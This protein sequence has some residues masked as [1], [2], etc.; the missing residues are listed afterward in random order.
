MTLRLLIIL[1]LCASIAAF[2]SSGKK[3][4]SKKIFISTGADTINSLNGFLGN[5]FTIIDQD[6]EVAVL[7]INADQVEDI[8]H[9]MHEEH[10]RCGGFFVHETRSEALEM[11]EVLGFNGK[12]GKTE[13]PDAPKYN[14]TIN[15]TE[16]V[17]G[18]LPHAKELP[19]RKVIQKLSSF[20][21]RHYQTETGIASSRWIASHWKKLGSARNDV[22]V[23]LVKHRRFPQESII[24]TITGSK[25]PNEIIVIGGHADSINGR[26]KRRAPG[27]DDN[28]S[29]IATISEIIRV[30]ML[31]G[32]KPERTVQF[33]GYA[34]EEV[35]LL[36]SADIAGQYKKTGK[37]V[38]G[39]MQLDM[40][41]HHGTSN[42]DIVMMSD[43][44][45][46][47]QNAFI[48]A[49]I[50]RYLGYSWGYSKCGY[51]CSDHASWTR[52][53]YAASIPFES[54]MNDINHKIHTPKDTLDNLGGDASH[55]L[56]FAKL[57]IA[58]MMELAK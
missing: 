48:G 27:A 47:Y 3:K 24:M 45:N 56:K 13:K 26:S 50:D 46:K 49:L 52:N 7:E 36:G 44:T 1:S 37:N 33:M 57:G 12:K 6:E 31:T 4:N 23:E 15:Q 40:T 9:H 53:K 38:I 55:A 30:A 42:K 11:I 10:K 8:A 29:G 18:S 5:D 25:Y 34:A 17:Q 20:E 19:I 39:V 41:G 2:A 54:T 16:K 58:F 43:F 28:A 22:K 14:Y 35:G 32:Y 21:T 51:G